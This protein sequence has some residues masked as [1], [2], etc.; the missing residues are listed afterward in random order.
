MSCA[1]IVVNLQVWT[2]PHHKFI[3]ID[4]VSFDTNQQGKFAPVELWLTLQDHTTC[5]IYFIS[6]IYRIT[7]RSSRVS[8][9]PSCH[10]HIQQIARHVQSNYLRHIEIK[11]EIYKVLKEEKKVLRYLELKVSCNFTLLAAVNLVL[12]TNLS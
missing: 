12:K 2:Y 1:Q 11:I 3:D 7:L 8:N 4:S 9:Y 6:Q 10:Y 5:I